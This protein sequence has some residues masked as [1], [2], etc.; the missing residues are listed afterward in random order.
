MYMKIHRSP[1]GEEVVAVCDR[2]LMNTTLFREGVEIR[3]RGDFYGER[4]VSADEVRKALANAEN[5]NL[6]G[7]RT[8]ALALEMGLIH[9][10]SCI[11][12][13]DVPHAQV[14]RI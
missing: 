11:M 13:G 10:S 2:E 14:F 8:V 4:T 12:L 9:R 5:A 6:M 7:K 3:I 1:K